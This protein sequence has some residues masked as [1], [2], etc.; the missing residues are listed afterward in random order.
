MPAIHLRLRGVV[1]R[2]AAFGGVT[3]SLRQHV[4]EF[5]DLKLRVPDQRVGDAMAL[6]LL[7]VLHPARVVVD[8]VDAESDDLAIALLELRH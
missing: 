1:C 6:G 3:G 8:R 4:I 5:G 7:D 2:S